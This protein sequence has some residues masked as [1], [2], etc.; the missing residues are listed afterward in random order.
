M[1]RKSRIG[2]MQL[3]GIAQSR[4]I[5]FLRVLYVVKTRSF[6][7]LLQYYTPEWD[8]QILFAIKNADVNILYQS[9]SLE[10]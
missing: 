2:R 7:Q 6:D 4:C 10:G 5:G 8:D 9:K 3:W 1:L